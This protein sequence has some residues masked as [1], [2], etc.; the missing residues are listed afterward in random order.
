MLNFD[1]INLKILYYKSIIDYLSS[2]FAHY[3]YI[4]GIIIILV[5]L[6]FNLNC[7]IIKQVYPIIQRYINRFLKRLFRPLSCINPYKALPYLAKPEIVT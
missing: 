2:Y 6:L 4:G 7:I 3:H 5:L 1:I